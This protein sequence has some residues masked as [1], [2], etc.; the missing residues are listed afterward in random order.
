VSDLALRRQLEEQGLL[1]QFSE[2]AINWAETVKVPVVEIEGEVW[3]VATEVARAKGVAAGDFRENCGLVPASSIK[4]RMPPEA[5]KRMLR[6]PGTRQE[7]VPTTLAVKGGYAIACGGEGAKA[8]IN[9]L[10]KKQRPDWRPQAQYT[11]LNLPLH[12]SYLMHGRSAE[13]K[14]TRDLTIGTTMNVAKAAAKQETAPMAVHQLAGI[15]SP[16]FL[17]TLHALI[18]LGHDQQRTEEK[19]DLSLER[20]EQALEQIGKLQIEVKSLQ[21]VLKPKRTS[22]TQVTKDVLMGVWLENYRGLCPCC[23]ELVRRKDLELDHWKS[24]LNSEPSGLWYVCGPCNV[25]MG[26]PVGDGGKKRTAE[27]E[28]KFHTFQDLLRMKTKTALGIQLRLGLDAA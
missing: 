20:S 11:L 7:W 10:I 4:N 21:P 25:A 27:H 16:E 26:A 24:K 9:A 12:L 14:A 17:A 3:A 2:D 28:R 13:A 5:I 23:E 8:G 1:S 19:A 6:I 22:P 18:A 15:K